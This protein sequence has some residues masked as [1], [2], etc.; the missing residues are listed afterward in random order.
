VKPEVKTDVQLNEVAVM[1][2]VLDERVWSHHL[3]PR[4]ERGFEVEGVWDVVVVGSVGGGHA[5][6][7]MSNSDLAKL[8]VRNCL[9]KIGHVSFFEACVEGVGSVSV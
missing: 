1:C 6:E 5:S 7:F 4:G 2:I 3:F 9:A 8:F